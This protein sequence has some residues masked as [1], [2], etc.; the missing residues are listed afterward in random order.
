MFRGTSFVANFCIASLCARNCIPTI[1]LLAISETAKLE[2]FCI[3][4][5]IRVVLEVL[6]GALRVTNFFVV[7]LRARNG[8]PAIK[9]LA[10]SKTAKLEFFL[11]FWSK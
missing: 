2:F 8:F 3:L 7:S 5:K 4:E 1:K 9:L 11:Y 10:I 6:H